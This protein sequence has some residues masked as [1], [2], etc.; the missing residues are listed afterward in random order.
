MPRPKKQWMI[1][2]G[3][4]ELAVGLARSQSVPP[5]VIL[6]MRIENRVVYYADTPDAIK[7]ATSPDST[8]PASTRTFTNFLSIADIVSINGRPVKGTWTIRA[9]QLN[10]SPNPAPGQAIADT[11]RQNQVDQVFEILQP[12]GTPIGTL[13]LLGVSSGSP[14]PG[15]PL[16]AGNTNSAVVGGTGAFLGARGQQE[17]VELIQQEHLA[18]QTEDPSMRRVLGA[19][20]GIR[21]L[22]IQLIPMFRPQIVS[23]STGP[24][25]FH[26]DFSPVTAAKPAKAGEVLLVKA[27]GVGP[28]RP[29]I[30]PGQPFPLDALQEVN[31]PV[32]VTVNG[33][34]AE[35]INKIGWPGLAD[36][37]RVDFRVPD[38]ITTGTAAIQLTVAWITGSS[39]NIP[40]Q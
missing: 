39:V 14:P 3:A 4:F 36:T 33:Q 12:N 40:A 1:A 25:V 11:T 2:L 38:G 16:I 8:T 21:R 29:G 37:Y 30:D 9:I 20:T 28:T 13:F 34:S 23:A 27:T 24:A 22:V 18:S 15:A 31:S 32:D 6:D 5:A 10:L 35:V 17:L 7:L 26:A 19:G